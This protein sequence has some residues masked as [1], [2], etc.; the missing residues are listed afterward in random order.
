MERR[1]KVP[2]PLCGM[3]VSLSIRFTLARNDPVNPHRLWRTARRAAPSKS[4]RAKSLARILLVICV[5]SACGAPA[6]AQWQQWVEGADYDPSVPD[7]DAWLGRPFAERHTSVDEI[8]G[9]AQALA[10]ASD[11]VTLERMGTSVQGDPLLLLVITEPSRKSLLAQRDSLVAVVRDPWSNTLEERQQA[12]RGLQPAV[13]IA[14]SVHG[15]EASGSEAA[16]LLAYHLAADRSAAT[17]E[18]LARTVV[19]VGPS[20]NPD[21]RRRFLQHVRDHGRK[22]TTPDP[23][24]W[25]AEHWQVWPGGR[26]NHFLFDLNRDW[27]F[28]TQQETRSHVAA[29]LRWRPQVFVDLHEMGRES[30]YFFPPPA[31]PINPNIPREHLEWF[32]T[33]GRANAE[34]FDARGFDYYVR[35]DFDLF[36]PGY[37][38]SWPTLQG[39]VGMTFEQATT[40]GR[41]LRQREGRIVG[42][43]EAVEHHFVAALTTLRTTAERSEELL[44]SYASFNEAAR[45]RADRDAR[46]EI[47]FSVETHGAEAARLAEVLARQGITVWRTTE[48]RTLRLTPYD[49]DRTRSVVLP[50]GSFRVPLEQAAY[51]L[52]RS[53]LDPHT[54]MDE[55][56]LEQERQRRDRGLHNRFYDVTAW[57]LV[58]SYGV[59]AFTA[60]RRL[61]VPSTT[62]EVGEHPELPL[63]RSTSGEESSR[64]GWAIAYEDN[65]ALEAL[66]A[67]WSHDVRVE[68]LLG[69]VVHAGRTLP[70]GSFLVKRVAN[71]HVPDLDTIVNDVALSTHVRLLAMDTAWTDRGPSLGSNQ[72]VP[73]RT[74]R[75]A[76]LT[77]PGVSPQSAGGL[78]WLLEDRYQLDFT[79]VLLSTLEHV[80]LSDFDAIL[81][82]E[83]RDPEVLPLDR[84]ASWVENGG[85][86]VLIGESTVAAVERGDDEDESVWTTVEHVRDL[87][88]LTDEDGLLGEFALGRPAP[89]DDPGGPLPPERRPLDTPGAI[90]Q[91]DLD[92]THYL[93]LGE[94]TVAHAPVLSDRILTASVNGRTV[95]RIP[96]EGGLR[97][98][99]M[100]PVMEEALKDKAFLVE[101]RRGRGRVIL[102]AEDPGFRGTWE[103]L[104]RLLLN[105]LLIGPS[106]RS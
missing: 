78:N 58:F 46:K 101:E 20:H 26:T 25:A 66:R 36:Y 87:A 48:S 35:E 104:H 103:G 72:S 75:I 61:D 31:D 1:G 18:L 41:A 81:V 97:A 105:G 88:E 106:M 22:S 60:D 39:A 42:Y 6:G 51:P 2:A 86:L 100:W 9:Y 94:G 10:Q 11:R 16:L 77:G 4:S 76:M 19:L 27:A 3:L 85:V 56:F 89:P 45:E 30:S 62:L 64:V 57:S 65:A 73:L 49:G 91:L 37:G 95:A 59:Q 96:L 38:D 29:F 102:F 67:L 33:F 34:A 79:T 83:L 40:R 74:S 8:L 98:G 52:V 7:P 70:R 32:E 54:P 82:P 99:F 55:G 28:L 23:S 12:L 80:D 69:S 13:W 24:P 44:A 21:G 53:L 63:D 17:G 71:A 84:L 15:D 14:G 90:V 68:C 47:V 5:V 43:R 93:T 92:P 50:A